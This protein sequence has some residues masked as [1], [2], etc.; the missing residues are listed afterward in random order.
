[1][2]DYYKILGLDQGASEE[3]IKKSYRKLSLKYHPDKNGGDDN[4]FKEISNA[5][6]KL[7]NPELDQQFNEFDMPFNPFDFI[8]IFNP[9]N[10]GPMNHGPMNHGPMNHKKRNDHLHELNLT[11]NE[12]H[13]GTTKKLKITLKKVC[14]KCKKQCDKCN[15]TGKMN[16][17][18]GPMIIQ[19]LCNNC[20]GEC[21]INNQNVNC[22]DCGGT[23]EIN[24]STIVVIEIPKCFNQ[25]YIVKTGLGEQIKNQN[26]TPGD[27]IFKINILSHQ[28]FKLNGVD[29]IYNVKISFKESIIG[30][31]IEIPHLDGP[32]KLNT[33]GFGIINPFKNYTLKNKGLCEVGDLIFKFEI[34]YPDGVLSNDVLNKIKEIEF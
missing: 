30:K 8:N 19:Q 6:Q 11:L 15:G 1:M 17:R 33:Q 24:T 34:E 31:D 2:T 4:K 16:I 23:C 21:V 27:L 29:L 12:I 32:I 25:Q 9:M 14:F 20:N 22:T 5:Y 18:H 26:E 3:E 10:H 28:Y 7:T 13:T